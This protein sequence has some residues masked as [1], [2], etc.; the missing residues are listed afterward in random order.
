MKLKVERRRRERRGK[1]KKREGR[2]K[3]MRKR[4]KKRR[5]NKS[6]QKQLKDPLPP[7][8]LPHGNLIHVLE[9]SSAVNCCEG[10]DRR[11]HS[12]YS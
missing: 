8:E 12:G 9:V 6:Q 2:K 3:R 5:K 7:S 11:L 10:A 4:K 1:R